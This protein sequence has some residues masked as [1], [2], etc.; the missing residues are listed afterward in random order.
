[1][2]ATGL[3]CARQR[4]PGGG[5]AVPWRSRA[6]RVASGTRRCGAV[7]TWGQ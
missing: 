3:S 7:L 6:E 2:R 4:G 1:M 5:R